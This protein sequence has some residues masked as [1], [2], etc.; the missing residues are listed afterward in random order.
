MQVREQPA[1]T[2]SGHGWPQHMNKW[3][4]CVD[5]SR[6]IALVGVIKWLVQHGFW[7]IGKVEW[8]QLQRARILALLTD[9]LE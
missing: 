6:V 2:N 1:F 4:M 8:A 3:H 7:Q 9:I 5:D